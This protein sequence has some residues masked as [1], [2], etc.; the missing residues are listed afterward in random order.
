MLEASVFLNNRTQAVRIP[1]PVRFASDI[2]KVS[3]RKMGN[4]RIISPVNHT[5][6][7]FFLSDER[8]DDDFLAER[9]TPNQAERLSLD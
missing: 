6:D 2:K 9:E 7:S 3:I 4:E 1:A 8:V 5:W